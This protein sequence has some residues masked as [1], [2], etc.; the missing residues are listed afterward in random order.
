MEVTRERTAVTSE[1]LPSPPPI[2][3]YQLDA[4]VNFL[5]KIKK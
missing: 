1:S 3:P 5:S 2:P 4:A